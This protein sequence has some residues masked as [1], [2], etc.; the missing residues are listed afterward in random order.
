MHTASVDV[1]GGTQCQ[2]AFVS[3]SPY[4]TDSHRSNLFPTQ[5]TLMRMWSRACTPAR[6]R[7]YGGALP[8]R[9]FLLRESSAF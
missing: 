5:R 3:R 9:K 8:R 1:N 6:S 7:P 2:A 4:R